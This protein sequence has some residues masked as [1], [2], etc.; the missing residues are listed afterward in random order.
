MAARLFT[1]WM[2]LFF[3]LIAC[4]INSKPIH[5]SRVVGVIKSDVKSLH[6]RV[7]DEEELLTAFLHNF[8]VNHGRR[9]NY[10]NV[11]MSVYLLS[12]DNLMKATFGFHDE[13]LLVISNFTSVQPRIMRGI[14]QVFSEQPFRSRSNPLVYFLVSLD[15]KVSNFVDDYLLDHPQS[16]TPIPIYWYELI[17]K[18]NDKWYIRNK[19]SS[20]LFTR[21]LFDYQL[22]LDDD[23]YFFGRSETVAEIVDSIRKSQN[24]GIFGLRKT[25][26]TSLLYKIDRI[27]SDNAIAT[28]LYID[29]KRP[30]IRSSTWLGLINYISDELC[31]RLAILSHSKEDSGVI[32]RFKRIVGTVPSTRRV[33][34]IFDEIEYISPLSKLNLHWSREFVDFWQTMWSIQ[35]EIR[36]LSFIIAGVNPY[37]IELDLIDGVQNPV[38]GIVKS[39]MIT[40]MGAD[41]VQ[42]MV[43]RIG[44]QMGLD[45]DANSL[46][47]L[48][49]R[50][51]GHPL[52]TRMAC[53][54]ANKMISV[55]HR[56]RPTTIDVTFLRQSE[57]ERDSELQFYCRHIVSELKEFYA[58]EYFMLE[59]LARGNIVEFLEL[60]VEPQWVM[61]L[62]GYGIVSFDRGGK[63]SIRLPVLERYVSAQ[64]ARDSGEKNLRNIVLRDKRQ[65]WLSVRKD[66]ILRDLKALLK[67]SSKR[68]IFQIYKSVFLPEAD[69]FASVSVCESWEGFKNFINCCFQS[70]CETI[71]KIHS[72][73]A[74][75]N[76]FK[77]DYPSLFDA[78]NRIRVYRND[79][80]HIVLNDRVQDALDAYLRRDLLGVPLSQVQEPWFVLQQIVLDEVFAAIQFEIN[81]YA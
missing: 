15:P 10:Y 22:P 57:R 36:R 68:S 2:R 76:D 67:H 45:F 46:K 1:N 26:K 28:V 73:Q 14:E 17:S 19:L 69:R 35:S 53:S 58:D 71:D 79:V 60:G 12:P 25:G 9:V 16:R 27:C 43:S 48:Y 49:E 30:D 13:I 5:G 44:R 38:F 34:V 3:Y 64:A 72:T 75:F 81:A 8:D 4:K 56:S 70:F 80:D 77:N 6:L 18:S 32:Q 63:P 7:H 42:M 50:Y 51:G 40:G 23:L 37:L 11:A 74:F 66:A 24:R 20:I 54:Y 31:K 62:K 39:T 61:H 52:L 21:D 47:Y 33:C 78:F 29:C 59:T 41:D 55:A 65:L